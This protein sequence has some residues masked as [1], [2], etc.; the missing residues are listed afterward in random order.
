LFDFESGY[1]DYLGDIYHEGFCFLETYSRNSIPVNV[2]SSVL[3]EGEMRRIKSES[4]WHTVAVI[5]E[6]TLFI[7]RQFTL[8]SHYAVSAQKHIPPD[9]TYYTFGERE[10]FRTGPEIHNL[11]QYSDD[12]G[13]PL[14][15]WDNERK[16]LRM[17]PWFPEEE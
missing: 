17:R 2:T 5:E 1:N 6:D 10:A 15:T 4:T 16:I 11:Y 14:F 12:V 3:H 13:Y 8:I 9:T 7:V